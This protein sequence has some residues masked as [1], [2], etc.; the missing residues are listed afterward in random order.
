M[1]DPNSLQ[2]TPVDAMAQFYEGIFEKVVRRI[3]AEHNARFPSV[4]ADLATLVAKIN[5]KP[6]ITVS[7]AALLLN[8]SE[9][10]LYTKIT[11]ARKKATKCPIPFLDLDGIY[12]FP[13]DKLI[14][15]A[16]RE[17]ERKPRKPLKSKKGGA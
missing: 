7:E 14:E 4:D 10:H 2:I 1:A 3:L 16:E 5:A 12:V 15:W 13:R 17:K 6:N 9:S 8:C 11:A